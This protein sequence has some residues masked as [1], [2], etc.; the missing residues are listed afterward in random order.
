MSRRPPPAPLARLRHFDLRQLQVVGLVATTV[1]VVL[2]VGEA[3]NGSTSPV[4]ASD[5]QSAAEVKPDV[6]TAEFCAA[7]E[8]LAAAHAAAIEETSRETVTGLKQAAT[9][10][11]AVATLTPTL[12]ANALDGLTYIV[13]LFE[14]IPDDATTVR[15]SV[16]GEKPSVTE[17]AHATEL[18]DFLNTE[19]FREAT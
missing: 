7:F 8:D 10:T 16:S 4:T 19:C 14:T 1:L 2:L 18:A 3:G 6:S 11:L 15:V 17:Q 13:E 9:D 5:D 12:G